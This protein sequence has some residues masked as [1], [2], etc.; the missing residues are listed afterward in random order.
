[1]TKRVP[2][3][4]KRRRGRVPLP[5]LE[6]IAV[7]C[8]FCRG[9][10]KDP[11][12]IMSELSTCCVCGGKGTVAIA[13]PYVACRACSGTGVEPFSRLTC[14]ACR[15]KGVV[16]A[17]QA[18]ERCPLC[19]GSGLHTSHLYCLRC[20]GAGVISLVPAG[21]AVEGSHNGEQGTD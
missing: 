19:N 13:E 10:G 8:A 18:T 1:M 5:P 2:S 17:I 11:F 7:Q 9:K 21:S 4:T 12:G 15:G 20:H 14:L 3:P 16:T 6:L